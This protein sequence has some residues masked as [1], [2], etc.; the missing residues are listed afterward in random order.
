MGANIQLRLYFELN[1]VPWA[2]ETRRRELGFVWASEI[3]DVLNVPKSFM[4]RINHAFDHFDG[5]EEKKETFCVDRKIKDPHRPVRETSCALEVKEI[6]EANPRKSMRAIAREKGGRKRQHCKACCARR[7]KKAQ[8]RFEGLNSF[9]SLRWRRYS[10][11]S[12]R[13]WMTLS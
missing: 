4:Y 5:P 13:C 6:A 8:R 7:P 2:N 1:N 3:T 11:T 10:S 12:P 9:Q